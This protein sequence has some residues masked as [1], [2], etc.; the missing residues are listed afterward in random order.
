[1]SDPIEN[2]A[3]KFGSL[4][5]FRCAILVCSF[6]TALGLYWFRGEFVPRS[7]YTK[8]QAQIASSLNAMEKVLIRMESKLE[9]DQRQDTTLA[10][11]ETR[12][13]EVENKERRNP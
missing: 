10:D 2:V 9:H 6:A 1:M 12:L 13:R 7:E 11:H 8:D 3:K 5:W 4:F